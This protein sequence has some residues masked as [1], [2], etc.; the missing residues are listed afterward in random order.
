MTG[1]N[2]TGFKSLP[3]GVVPLLNLPV[4]T[5]NHNGNLLCRLARDTRPK[6]PG[7][8]RYVPVPITL[9]NPRGKVL[10][11]DVVT[12]IDQI[13]LEH[14]APNLVY[15]SNIGFNKPLATTKVG[16]PAKGGYQAEVHYF[17]VGLDDA[18]KVQLLEPQLRHYLD[19]DSMGTKH[20]P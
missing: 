2:Y 13:K 8:S 19:L 16:I 10:Q 4:A 1:G 18:E 9:R 5:I 7:L 11:F 20:Q 14:A 3:P 6:R 17:A 12:I 15:V